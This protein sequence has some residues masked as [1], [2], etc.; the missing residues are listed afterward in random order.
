[1]NRRE[2]L[3]SGVA[4]ASAAI[5]GKVQAADGHEHHHHH[6]GVVNNGLIAATSDCIKKDKFA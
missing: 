2:L 1:M 4:L 5:V 3:L 6:G